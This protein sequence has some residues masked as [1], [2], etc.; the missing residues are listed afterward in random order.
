MSDVAIGAAQGAGNAAIAQQLS[1]A[2]LKTANDAQKAEGQAA[3]EL[4]Q[5]AAAANPGPTGNTIDVRA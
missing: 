3:I 4:I 1:V 2:A 5:T